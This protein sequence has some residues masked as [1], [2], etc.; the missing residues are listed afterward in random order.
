MG[1]AT[2]IINSDG[3]ET[4]KSAPDKEKIAALYTSAA[5]EYDKIGSYQLGLARTDLAL[6]YDDSQ[7]RTYMARGIILSHLS[8]NKEA[9]KNFMIAME[10]S[11]NDGEITTSYAD[12]LCQNKQYKEALVYYNKSINNKLYS[13]RQ[14]AKFNLGQCYLQQRYYA[15]ANLLFLDVATTAPKYS[16][17]TNLKL[18]ETYYYLNKRELAQYYFSKYRGGYS[19]NYWLVSLLMLKYSPVNQDTALQKYRIKQNVIINYPLSSE[20]KIFLS[21]GVVPPVTTKD[22]DSTVKTSNYITLQPNNN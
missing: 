17:E 6:S 20:A 10:K 4:E 12:F 14:T 9:E 3:T 19:L 16:T 8:D 1:C 5:L 2:T 21:E 18:A 22:V 7:G 11:P 13:S 15:Y